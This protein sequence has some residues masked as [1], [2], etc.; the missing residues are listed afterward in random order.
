MENQNTNNQGAQQRVNN[1]NGRPQTDRP[2]FNNDRK[3]AREKYQGLEHNRSNQAEHGPNSQ[4]DKARNQ[5][6]QK[7]PQKPKERNNDRSRENGQ[8]ER[9][10]QNLPGAHGANVGQGTFSK[11]PVH[12]ALHGDL[13]ARH[14]KPKR[15]ETV[16]DIK[17]DTERIEKDIQFEIKQIRSA[18]LGL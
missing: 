9:Y 10:H 14:I 11:V 5:A 15:I 7:Y 1:Q 4:D 8:P 12:N 17:A 3:I 13:T 6:E 2:R 16:E 18:K